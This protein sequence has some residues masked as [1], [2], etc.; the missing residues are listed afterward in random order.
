MCRHFRIN[1]GDGVKTKFSPLGF[2]NYEISP[3]VS[4]GNSPRVRAVL[5]LKLCNLK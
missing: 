4:A 2:K 3:V 1:L 5:I